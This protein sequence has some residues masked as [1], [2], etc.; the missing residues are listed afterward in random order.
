MTADPLM[1]VRTNGR[2]EIHTD[3]AMGLVLLEAARRDLNAMSQALG[4]GNELRNRY[5]GYARTLSEA[6]AQ[7]P[8]VDLPTGK[9]MEASEPK[10]IVPD[11]DVLDVIAELLPDPDPFL[12]GI[13]DRTQSNED[14]DDL[15][16]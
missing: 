6:A 1:I 12:A 15:L 7:I 14:L 4:A 5:A 10:R 11:E 9:V 16:G 3:D 8:R 13:M 2:L